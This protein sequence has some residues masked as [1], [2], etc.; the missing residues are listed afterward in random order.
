MLRDVAIHLQ[1]YVKRIQEPLEVVN[2]LTVKNYLLQDK[3]LELSFIF[4]L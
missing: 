3:T 4:Q 1:T 2:F